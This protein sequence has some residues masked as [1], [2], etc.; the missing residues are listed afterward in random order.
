MPWD[1]PKDFPSIYETL[2]GKYAEGGGFQLIC[3]DQHNRILQIQIQ[4][5][6]VL[7]RAIDVDDIGRLIGIYSYI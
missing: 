3:E 6:Q 7:Y 5:L 2:T 4:C 1:I